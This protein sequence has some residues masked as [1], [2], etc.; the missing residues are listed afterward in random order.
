MARR[1]FGIFKRASQESEES[2]DQ[3]PEEGTAVH[4]LTTATAEPD[5]VEETGDFAPVEET[6]EWE[7]EYQDEGTTDFEA[8]SEPEAQE[9]P[10][11]A[12]SEPA[13]LPP[14]EPE[15]EVARRI[16]AAAEAAAQEAGSVQTDE[17]AV[18][19]QRSEEADRIAASAAAEADRRV[20][21]AEQ[22]ASEAER[23]AHQAEQV[24]AAAEAR[25][26]ALE[27]RLAELEVAAE[28]E[29]TGR[30]QGAP[31]SADPVGEELAELRAKVEDEARSA[32]SRWL[33]AQLEA[34]R[35][36]ADARQAKAVSAARAEAEREALERVSASAD[37]GAGLAA[38]AHAE[39]VNGLREELTRVQAKL[40]QAG[41]PH[42]NGNGHDPV[43]EEARAQARSAQERAERAERELAAA[44]KRAAADIDQSAEAKLNELRAELEAVRAELTET[45]PEAA[46]RI[47]EKLVAARQAAEETLG[48]ELRIRTAQLDREREARLL[49]AEA[50]EMR[51]RTVEDR[52]IEAAQRIAVAAA[53][54]PGTTASTAT[55][56]ADPPTQV[57]LSEATYSELLS[58]GMSVGQAKRVLRRRAEQG[59]FSSLEELDALAEFAP[60]APEELRSRLV[61]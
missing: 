43:V 25:A 23:I 4:P 12:L 56:V 19:E 1:R 37:G 46:R 35:E 16:R 58:S 52:A 42:T 51:L 61:P 54:A 20:A 32:A 10:A 47:E 15:G 9:G 29:E 3:V 44:E 14:L 41:S 57:S 48:A 22:R 39:E 55:A 50:A 24:A 8:F 59:P 7:P 27:Q 17:V 34:A 53:T 31:E 33:R 60:R 5:R 2:A 26:S 38:E 36:A 13:P 18:L 45:A 6:G 21:A 49:A 30:V 40:D 28:K 11:D